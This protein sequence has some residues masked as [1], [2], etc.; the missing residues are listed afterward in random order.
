MGKINVDFV[1]S[2]G[3]TW[4]AASL[5]AI[6]LL[7]NWPD[8][9]ASKIYD[10]DRDTQSDREREGEECNGKLPLGRG[11]RKA[12]DNLRYGLLFFWPNE[13]L[14]LAYTKIE[15]VALPRPLPIKCGKGGVV[16][17]CVAVALSFKLKSLTKAR[18]IR[19]TFCY[20][21]FA[22]NSHAPLPPTPLLGKN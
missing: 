16:G 21:Q 8:N 4:R 9:W 22:A 20:E 15:S 6:C 7:H 3:Q 13:N 19:E 12:A 5:W 1:S 11:K 10:F 2:L 14:C 18:K 17:L